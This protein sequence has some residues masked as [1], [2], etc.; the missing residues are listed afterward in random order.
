MDSG[1]RADTTFGARAERPVGLR[2]V[3]LLEYL[4]ECRALVVDE[5][6][7]LVPRNPRYGPILYDLMLEY[8]LRHAKGLRPALCIATCRAFGGGLEPS[9]RSAATLELYHNAFLIHDDVEDGSELRRGHPTLHR[10]HGIPIAVN[11]GDA[12]LA[13]ALQPLLD[14]TAQVGLGKALRVL[15]IVARMARASAEGQ[16]LELSWARE[17]RWLV[18]DADYARMVYRKTSWYT[19]IAP[20]LIGGVLAGASPSQLGTLRGFAAALGIAFQIQDD[21]LNLTADPER[22]GKELCGDL[23]E[24][25][26]TLVLLHLLR[27]V[28]PDART[29]IETVLRKARPGT[30]PPGRATKSTTDIATLR[31]LIEGHGSVHYARRAARRWTERACRQLGRATATLSASVHRDLLW[32]LVDFVVDRDH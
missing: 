13:L 14:N 12:M 2:T 9:L 16:A 11:V 3:D 6:R 22:Y 10:L 31:G 18:S 20:V 17:G 5:I 30:A 29:W 24:G 7:R 1:L 25:K 15:Q 27:V 4:E 23:W 26:H 32:G 28:E 21:V 19:F 8:P